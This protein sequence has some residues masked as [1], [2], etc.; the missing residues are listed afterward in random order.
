MVVLKNCKPEL[1]YILAELF[2]ICLEE[3]CFP[4]FWK[5]SSVVPLFKNVVGRS[6]SK[7]YH[8]VSLL[9]VVS[10]VFEKSVNNR[11]VDHLE[12]YGAF[13]DFQFGSRSSQS[14][15][16]L[17]AVVSDRNAM[18][19]SRSWAT[20]AVAFDISKAFDRVWHIGLLHKRKFYGISGQIGLIST[21]ISNRQLWVVLDGK[22]SPKSPINA[23][24]SQGSILGPTFFL[25][26]IN[27]LPDD[28]ICNV[29]TYVDDTTLFFKCDQASDLRQQL[30]LALGLESDLGHTVDWGKKW[31]WLV[32][33]NAG[34]TQ[35]VLL[36]HCSNSTVTDVKMNGSVLLKK[37]SFKMLGLILSLSLFQIG[38]EQ[39]HY[40]YC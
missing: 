6:T 14:S 18:A 23:R 20:R 8:P 28:V 36:G 39:L 13:S 37:S 40:L 21:F 34:K 1:S 4:D 19:F 5:V 16:D 17:L 35:L 10:K 38:L 2:N 24:V 29:A 32:G 12:I 31:K 15:A 25:L 3:C 33:V 7:S 11:I 27:G 22:S 30:E 26:Y 9:S